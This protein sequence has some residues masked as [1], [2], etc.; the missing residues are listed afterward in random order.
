MGAV[1]SN[2][3]AVF[4]LQAG[5]KIL[6]ANAKAC[7]L[8]HLKPG[9][10]IDLER[11]SR[12]AQ[13]VD[14]FLSLCSSQG[15]C[16]FT[17][18]GRLVDGVSYNIPQTAEAD[19][20][21]SLLPPQLLLTLHYP[22]LNLVSA[23][24]LDPTESQSFST[25]TEIN[26]VM[27]AHL[28]LE[29]AISAVFQAFEQFIPVDVIVL[30][31]FERDNR[32]WLPYSMTGRPGPGRLIRQGEP[33]IAGSVKTVELLNKDRKPVFSSGENAA[34]DFIWSR[35]LSAEPLKAYL[36][37]PLLAGEEIV[38]TLELGS[39]AP[40]AFDPKYLA[41]ANLLSCLAAQTLRNAALFTSEQHRANMA[42]GLAQLARA[43]GIS[44]TPGELL[45]RVIEAITPLLAVELLGFLLYDETRHSLE[46]QAPF[47]GLPSEFL[48]L[49]RVDIKPLSQAETALF[50]LQ[51]VSSE[52]AAEDLHWADL[53]LDGLARAAGLRESVLVPVV[54]SGR[55]LGYLQA[56]NHR[57]HS[58]AFEEEELRI[59][60]LAAAIVAPLLALSRSFRFEHSAAGLSEA[61]RG[62]PDS[63]AVNRAARIRD[64]LE[65]AVA[66]SRQV[67]PQAV[68]STLANEWLILMDPDL[69]LVAEK[70]SGGIALARILGSIPTGVKP[71]TFFG[72]YNP[73]RQVFDTRQIILVS[74][75]EADLEWRDAPLLSAL[76]A[77]GLICLPLVVE[78]KVSAAILAVFSQPQPPFTE[79]DRQVYRHLVHQVEIT[80]QNLNLLAE[81]RRRLREVNLLLEFSRLLE[82]LD[83]EAILKTLLTSAMQALPAVSA[84]MVAL[85]D[86]M[87]KCLLPHTAS[88]YADDD[89][90][91]EIVYRLEETGNAQPL[92]L[93]VL[94]GGEPRR[95][96]EL[97]FA[98]EFP[99]Q[100]DDLVRYHRATGGSLPVSCL[101]VPIRSGEVPLG[102]LLLD[103][104]VISAA[105][106]SEDETLTASLAQ[107]TAL[108]LE[109]ARLY[110]FSEQRAS[111]L[112]ALTRTAEA[113]TS[114][115]QQDELV[116]SLLDQLNFVISFD[117][118]ALWLRRDVS[119]EVSA[120]RGFPNNEE[121][122]GLSVTI[123]DNLLFAEILKTGQPLFIPDVR[124]DTRFDSL[125]FAGRQSWLGLPLLAKGELIGVIAL[126]K[127][128]GGYYSTEQI[129]AAGT[130][131]G[132]ATI[133]LE[134][135]R[136][137]EESQN[138]AAEL[139]RRSHRLALLNRL[140]G[141]L[142]ASRK[143]DD[144]LRLVTQ[145]T[146]RALA[147]STV[148]AVLFNNQGQAELHAEAPET[149]SRLPLILP[150]TPFFADLRSRPGIASVGNIEDEIGLE[151]LK[152]FLAARRTC[153]LL[154]VPVMSANELHGILLLHTR[155]PYHFTPLETEFA[156]TIG[157]QA[158][159]AIQ[160]LR[161]T[162]NLELRIQE[163]T[164]E[165]M[166]EHR[167]SETL[168]GVITALSSSLE[169]D[170]VLDQTLSLV[171]ASVEAGQSAIFLVKD[172][173]VQPY[174]RSA[175]GQTVL[176]MSNGWI[177][178]LPEAELA[179][180]VLDR[181]QT[182]LIDD[183]GH[184]QEYP[185]PVRQSLPYQCAIGVLLEMGHEVLG[186]LAL[187]HD[188]PGGFSR[189]Q[190]NLVEAVARQISV[191]LHNATLF[192]LVRDQAENLAKMLRF[193]QVEASRSRAILEAVADGVL[194]TDADNL[195]T[196]FNISAERHLGLQ[197]EQVIGQSLEQFSGLFGRSGRTWLNTIHLWS[198]DPG[199]YRSG[200]AY[201]DQFSLENG[202]V[203][204]I[205][206]APVFLDGRF[207]G[208]VSIF[209]DITNEVKVDRMK[210][211]FVA[212]VSHEL[213][214]PMTSI[215]GYVDLMLM[216]ASGAFNEQQQ[217]FLEII[218]NNTRR[219]NILV[220]GLLDVSRIEAG[221]VSLSSEPL[222]I[223][224]IAREVISELRARSHE[225]SKLMEFAIDA[226][227]G[228]TKVEA[229][230]LH[231]RQV[232]TN[233][234]T[235]AYNYTPENG[236][237]VI[238]IHCDADYLQV[239]VEDTGVGIS[240]EEQERIF[241]RFYR[242]EHPLVLATSGTGLGLSIV[243]T[244]VEMHHGQIW[245]SSSGEPGKGSVFSFSLPLHQTQ[246]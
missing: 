140:S 69:V 127:R 239:D 196:L 5:G 185:I 229:D 61:D 45:P 107:Q 134:N 179:N 174:F 25:F 51:P 114:N 244:L 88:G 34:P 139:D 142:G 117:T 36:G 166:R 15:C 59:L 208:T 156:L 81:T 223:V 13:P 150:E 105:F 194:V 143:P 137:F 43:A 130:F 64:A 182:V 120:A 14:A 199:S 21:D 189:G 74:D 2:D 129:R 192:N 58:S 145:Q 206:L 203:I 22:E 234:A 89:T 93:K 231:I 161:L 3:D 75:L 63:D 131:A 220:N 225:E 241:E 237:V 103:N 48:P 29:K 116:A 39:I 99:L 91:L 204:A 169:I 80:L 243:K 86:G 46:G 79:E 87:S 227:P 162:Q 18:D 144:V 218:K 221:Q 216:G 56:S 8:F 9:K 32:T 54:S 10:P 123:S 173:S 108:A 70:T 16:R 94:L 168:L 90:L 245:F 222:D 65:I 147:C 152:D 207:L 4:L 198:T 186:V 230:P 210:S 27:A 118:A 47:H 167:N 78:E 135:A 96:D 62:L 109:N 26:R 224:E 111:Q 106:T 201:R 60:T 37:L 53:G 28:D 101:L 155:T 138:K 170:R 164:T 136:L 41:L 191:A 232:I 202:R 20:P 165:M 110:S 102:L 12:R 171:N 6:S 209:R 226:S 233:L 154:F 176:A 17:I 30:T 98:Q 112:Q 95:I 19:N 160:N 214:T 177:V 40:G 44:Q 180:L 73:L 7:H 190:L 124:A 158:D 228:L 213:R 23:P 57:D 157:N 97:D 193:Q 52:N 238:H 153:S 72:Q 181:R 197:P 67:T 83:P 178:N 104:F 187:Y 100:A 68:L 215:K 11:L 76:N 35:S 84:G 122:H 151:P 119:F 85:W 172:G 1:G 240:K 242:G 31:V 125:E 132:Q 205:N 149:A 212:N 148:S 246:E 195:V 50:E 113:M 183:L 188:K 184:N 121:L 163:R 126:E 211:E 77:R 71:D 217:R 141:E 146:M 159:V 92:P 24:G 55:L 82:S 133:A 235:N 49:Y 236:R 33:Q 115:L 42:T 66:A 128:E 200:E 175:S 38:G 219:L